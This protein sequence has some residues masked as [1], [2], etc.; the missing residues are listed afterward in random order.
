M[1]GGVKNGLNF[2]KRILEQAGIDG[3]LNNTLKID[4]SKDYPLPLFV[5]KGLRITNKNIVTK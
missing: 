4:F 1:G 3:I 2:L 5:A